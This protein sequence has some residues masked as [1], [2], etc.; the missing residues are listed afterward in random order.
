MYCDLHTHSNFSDG[1]FSPAELVAEAARL[2]LSAI[3]LTDHNTVAGLPE[4]LAA[5]QGSAVETI[6]GCEFSA[7]YQGVELHIVGLF[8]QPEHYEAV[9][10]LLAQAQQEKERSNLALVAALKENGY[11]VD[12]AQICSGYAGQINRAHFAAALI[13][14]G[15]FETMQQAFKGPLSAKHGFYQ[16]PKRIDAYDCIRFI[17][18]IG[19]VA[20][21]AHPFLSLEEEALRAFLPQAVEAGLDAM[22]VS[23]SKYSP[24]TTAAAFAVADAFGLRYSGG[25][26]F[27][28]GNKPDIALGSGRGDL[29]VPLAW[30]QS[31]KK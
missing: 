1:T 16:P 11:E 18:S 13:E 12:Y 15:Y 4:F 7:D 2:G 23:Y 8:I 9:T 19:A 24:E 25:S 29:K 21:L 3:A 17:K 5:G 28:G 14:K 31:L 10:A 22:E 26:D 30:L 27:H 6:P 20:I